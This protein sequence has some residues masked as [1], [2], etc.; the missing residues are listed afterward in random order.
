MDFIALASQI[1]GRDL[2]GFL[3]AWL[4]GKDT[5]PMPGHSDWK[6]D[7]TAPAKSKPHGVSI[8]KHA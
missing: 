4:Y 2:T 3:D 7:D 5:P 1:S 6:S 8:T